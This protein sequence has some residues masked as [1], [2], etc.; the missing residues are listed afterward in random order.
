VKTHQAECQVDKRFRDSYGTAEEWHQAQPM[1][2][3]RLQIAGQYNRTQSVR[4]WPAPFGE[5]RDQKLQ[6]GICITEMAKVSMFPSLEYLTH[7]HESLGVIS[8]PLL[9][10]SSFMKML[11][12]RVW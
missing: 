10:S 7:F 9:K 12:A 1:Y 8:C 6:G 2:L 3:H 4:L 5:V 11:K